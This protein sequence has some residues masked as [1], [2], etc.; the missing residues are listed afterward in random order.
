MS[1][2]LD[3]H[4]CILWVHDWTRITFWKPIEYSKK[5]NTIGA[6]PMALFEC[7]RCGDVAVAKVYGTLSWRGSDEVEEIRA[8]GEWTETIM[9]EM[10]IYP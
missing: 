6:T 9:Q 7:E 1:D 10:D 3:K 8:I 5:S 4:I 2:W